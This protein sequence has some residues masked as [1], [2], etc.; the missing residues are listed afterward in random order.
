VKN[1]DKTSQRMKKD[2][3]EQ[4]DKLSKLFLKIGKELSNK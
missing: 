1:H 2:R 4:T 3:L